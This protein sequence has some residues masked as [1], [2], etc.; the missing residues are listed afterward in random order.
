MDAYQVTTAVA[1]REDAERIAVALVE[2][3]LAACVQ[4]IGPIRSI[5][6]WQGRVEQADEWM[7]LAKTTRGAYAAVEAAI[8][9]IHTY[10]CPEIIATQLAEGSRDY[11]RWL[12]E[13]VD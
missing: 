3:R 4:I 5:Y 6:R 12:R 2:R 10:E 11:L 13:Q 1:S 8:R 9:E 7:C